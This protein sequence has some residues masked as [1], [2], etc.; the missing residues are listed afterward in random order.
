MLKK[1]LM[2]YKNVSG[3]E[4]CGYIGKNLGSLDFHHVNSNKKNFLVMTELNRRKKVLDYILRE[5]DN[6]KIICSNCHNIDH[7][8]IN[9]FKKCE[10][11]IKGFLVKNNQK[12]KVNK[13]E[14]IR[15]HKLGVKNAEIAKRIRCAKSSITYILSKE[16]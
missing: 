9:R 8:N 2:E 7:S 11:R 6:C 5:V 13:D 4:K 15:L 16:K 10:N 12:P 14:V 1:K 3:C